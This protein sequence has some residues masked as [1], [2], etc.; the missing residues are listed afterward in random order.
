MT[1]FGE[2]S[3]ALHSGLDERPCP[4]KG[5]PRIEKSGLLPTGDEDVLAAVVVQRFAGES[6]VERLQAEARNVEEPQPFVLRRPPE[7]TGSAL[8]QGDVDTVVADAVVVRVCHRRVG[9]PAVESGCEVMIERE[10]VPGEAA[11]RPKRR[12]DPLETA[13]SIRPGGQV[14]RRPAGAVD[15]GCGLREL[16]LAYVSFA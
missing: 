13:A 6:A 16:E 3:E 5:G 7:R 9:V 14:Q 2:D 4:T 8:V 10:C 11:L 1:G 12:R 15:Q